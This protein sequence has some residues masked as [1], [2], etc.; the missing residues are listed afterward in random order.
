M[1][2]EAHEIEKSEP[3]EHLEISATDRE[4]LPSLLDNF[5]TVITEGMNPQEKDSLR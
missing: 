4:M 2:H 1:Q 3:W 5:E